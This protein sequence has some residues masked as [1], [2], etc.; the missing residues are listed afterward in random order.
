[1]SKPWWERILDTWVE[2]NTPSYGPFD[3]YMSM[4]NPD[5]CPQLVHLV[6]SAHNYMN[7]EPDRQSAFITSQFM[8]SSQFK[9]IQKHLQTCS[10][11]KNHKL[12]KK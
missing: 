5:K 11:C 4:K 8:A 1:M 9:S 7:D 10:H 6:V 3:E 2:V 12:L